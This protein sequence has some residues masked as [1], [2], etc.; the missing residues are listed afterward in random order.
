M[1]GGANAIA[2]RR[3]VMHGADKNKT[4]FVISLGKWSLN[5]GIP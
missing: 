4:H 5:P 1:E 2:T 3:C